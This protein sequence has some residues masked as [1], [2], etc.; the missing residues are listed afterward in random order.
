MWP[1][2]LT[3]WAPSLQAVGLW[4]WPWQC[5]VVPSDCNCLCLAMNVGMR[6]SCG[7]VCCR[8]LWTS[9][10]QH[11]VVWQKLSTFQRNLLSSFLMAAIQQRVTAVLRSFSKGV[12][13]DSFQKLYERCRPCTVK[14]R[15][16]FEGQ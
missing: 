11:R 14:D 1:V 9:K 8:G 2:T 16:Y 4:Q 5:Y 6:N 7:L 10:T 13:A 15:D 3:G 12:F